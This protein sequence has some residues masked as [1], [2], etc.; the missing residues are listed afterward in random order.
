MTGPPAVP[1]MQGGPDPAAQRPSGIGRAA[2]LIAALTVLARLL[3]LVRTVVFSQTVGSSCLGTA[4]LTANNLPNIIYDIVLG[5]ALTAIMVPI[6]ARPAERS[7]ADPAAASEVGRTSAAMLTWTVVILVPVSAMLAFA[8]GPIAGLL[9]PDNPHAGCV[10][11]QL[12]TVTGQMMAVFAPQILLYGLAVVLYGVLQA[13]R[14][15]AAPALA[16]VISSLVVIGAYLAFIPWRADVNNLSGLPLTA[17]LILSVGTTCGVAALVLTALVPA[18]RLRLRLRPTLRFP[19]GIGRRAAGLAGFGAAAVLAQD[20]S[21]LVVIILA[22]SNGAHAAL[23]LYSYGWQVFEAAYAVLAISIAVS[24]FPALSV[25]EGAEL[26]RVGAG[27]LR[28]VLLMSFLGTALLLAI[29]VPAAHA[30]A[31]S[32]DQVPQLAAGIALFAPGLAGYGLMACLSRLLLATGRSRLAAVAVSGGWLLV[33]VADV[34]L[35]LLVTAPW[36]VAMLALGNTIGLTASGIA[37]LVT[38]WRVSGPAALTGA[39]RVAV[40]GLAAS[41]AGAAAGAGAAAALSSASG[42][43]TRLAEGGAAVLAAGCALA[44]FAA[45]AYLLDRGELR[46]AV[47]RVRRMVSR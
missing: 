36:V 16:P 37:L 35:V 45:V 12:V 28:A 17:R 34:L 22:N 24:A 30:L 27:S 5:G 25:R 26:D 31:H 18:W 23:V 46:A 42:G 2:A 33:I 11:A 8:A 40:S 32:S 3:G 15:F 41:A 19:A 1:V 4:Y 39:R 9:N 38:V 10:H 13:H 20:A 44:V 6:L 43:M 7:A 29:C 14:R 21:S 47:A